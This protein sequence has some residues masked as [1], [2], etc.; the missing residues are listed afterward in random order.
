MR[1]EFIYEHR[2]QHS[3]MVL[4]RVMSVSRSGY[5]AWRDRP[6]SERVKRH[7][8]LTKKIRTASEE[9][10]GIY[11]SPRIHRQLKDAGEVVSVNTVA[12][13]MKNSG[14]QARM[15]R[16]FVVTTNSRHK[17]KHSRTF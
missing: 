17:Q 6:E 12:R 5:Y 9:F 8:E 13:L 16:R 14:L 1:Y 15:H 11:G 10:K 2:T 4:C 7:R 3:I